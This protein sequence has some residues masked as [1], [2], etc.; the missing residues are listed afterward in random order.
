MAPLR[1]C[2]RLRRNAVDSAVAGRPANDAS[3][4]A[5]APEPNSQNVA[6]SGTGA[7]S[8]RISSSGKCRPLVPS[9]IATQP[10]S[11]RLMPNAVPS[12]LATHVAPDV[13]EDV[14]HAFEATACGLPSNEPASSAPKF[15]QSK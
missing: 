11:A 13:T 9:A 10:E 4:T 3:I 14:A 12:G 5:S 6:G 7:T 8:A 2:A 1:Y 15:G